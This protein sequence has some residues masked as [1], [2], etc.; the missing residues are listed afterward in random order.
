MWVHLDHVHVHVLP[1]IDFLTSDDIT[2]ID[3]A[4]VS[5]ISVVIKEDVLS[6]V[7]CLVYQEELGTVV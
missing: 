5:I 6:V 1:L 2:D 3:N 4:L 7:V